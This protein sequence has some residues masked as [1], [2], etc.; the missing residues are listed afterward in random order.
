PLLSPPQELIY[1]S[2]ETV[3]LEVPGKKKLKI[4]GSIGHITMRQHV[5][6]NIVNS[7]FE[8]LPIIYYNP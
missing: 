3:S 8:F 4:S 1:P 5:Q 6:E 7:L 2:G